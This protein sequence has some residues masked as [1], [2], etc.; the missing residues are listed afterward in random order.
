MDDR[1]RI[2]TAIAPWRGRIDQPPPFTGPDLCV[3]ALALEDKPM[4]DMDICFWIWKTFAFHNKLGQALWQYWEQ[5]WRPEASTSSSACM[6]KLPPSGFQQALR[7]YDMLLIRHE[8]ETDGQDGHG[9]LGKSTEY[10]VNLTEAMLYLRPRL[11]PEEQMPGVF[12]FLSLP[13]DIRNMV[14]DMVFAL[15]PSGIRI[16]GHESDRSGA[17]YAA[18]RLFAKPF[19]F[20]L[21]QDEDSTLRVFQ[22]A[23]LCSLLLVNR[24]IRAEA[25][26]VFPSINTFYFSSAAHMSLALRTMPLGYRQS[27]RHIAL[28]HEFFAY[29]GDAVAD[30]FQMLQQMSSLQT[31]RV[32]IDGQA[33][34]RLGFRV[35]TSRNYEMQVFARAPA[36]PNC[37]QVIVEGDC[38]QEIERQIRAE[39]I[40]KMRSADPGAFTQA[41]TSGTGYKV[42]TCR[43]QMLTL[44][45]VW[46]TVVKF[47]IAWMS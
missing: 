47:F 44:A 40:A 43:M 26:Y 9:A 28:R 14:Y 31:L 25:L 21:W 10:T 23:E 35:P 19:D 22:M 17:V 13:P 41:T 5:E 32:L 3:I 30:G 2:E 45:L 33:W 38:T 36:V 7:S 1:S 4:T 18:T 42:Q 34:H 20:G 37:V 15:P 27:I 46:S 12:P 8:D 16:H 24:Q 11:W 39:P 29:Q 6:Q